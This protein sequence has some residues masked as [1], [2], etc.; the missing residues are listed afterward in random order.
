[1]SLFGMLFAV[2]L[3]SARNA[4]EA[5]NLVVVGGAGGHFA[6]LESIASSCCNSRDSL[7]MNMLKI[8]DLVKAPSNN[9]DAI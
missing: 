5:R 6:E 8:E 1:M 4:V 3:P 9:D 2:F 7:Y